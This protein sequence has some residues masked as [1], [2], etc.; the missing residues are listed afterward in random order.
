MKLI[1]EKAQ[2]TIAAIS[3]LKPHIRWE[4]TTWELLQG[5]EA[6]TFGNELF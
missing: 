5:G 3:F 4:I 2:D 6:K 1:T